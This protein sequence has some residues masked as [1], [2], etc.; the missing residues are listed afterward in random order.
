MAHIVTIEE[1]ASRVA[2]LLHDLN[3][4]WPSKL[5]K[6][7]ELAGLAG[8]QGHRQGQHSLFQ[9]LKPAVGN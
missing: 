2:V 3:P 9:E 5:W 6:Q 1:I 4:R 8:A 7:Q